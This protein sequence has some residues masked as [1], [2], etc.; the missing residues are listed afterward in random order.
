MKGVRMRQ[1]V[2]RSFISGVAALALLTALALTSPDATRAQIFQTATL[3]TPIV[4]TPVATLTPFLTPTATLPLLL[5]TPATGCA[6]P[7]ALTVGS[8]IIVDGGLNVR[9]TPSVSGVLLNYFADE[10]LVRLIDGPVCA[11][12]YNWWRVAGIG[13]P[14]WIIEGTP[15]RYFI[16]T[17]IDPDTVNCFPP[18][19]GIAVGGQVRAVTGSR[20]RDAA[21]LG[22][23]V[24]T[25]AQPGSLLTI[26][27]GPR[28]FDGLI[29]WRVR[30]N[31]A[32]T[33][34]VVEGWIGEGY[35]GEYWIEPVTAA[36]ATPLP[37]ARPL[38]WS[39]GTRG[40]AVARDG[41]PRRLRAAPDANAALLLELIDGVAFEVLAAPPTC[42]GGYNWWSVRIL[43][44][45]I[46][47]W[48]AEGT[49][50]R[51]NVETVVR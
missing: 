12:G 51:Y 14:G 1:N 46:T 32:V 19:A 34:A 24:I 13:E 2:F 11:N 27:E 44:T 40:A 3:G 5:V 45:G 16:Q 37:C 7:L 48:I 39:V 18:R 38:G 6:A 41:V 10:K 43:T 42:A 21:D 30:T 29:W 49:P 22:A 9:Y 17:Y 50:G 33:S 20:V 31:F 35:P 47:G 8:Q 26:L 15:G 25:V 36:G 4:G 28:C 23:F